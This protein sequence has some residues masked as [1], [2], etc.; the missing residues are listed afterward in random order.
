MHIEQKVDIFVQ[1]FYNKNRLNP[2]RKQVVLARTKLSVFV[3]ENV[4]HRIHKLHLFTMD[5]TF[6][7]AQIPETGKKKPRFAFL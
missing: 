1:A 3:N 7:C 2:P 6:S 4:Y 5:F